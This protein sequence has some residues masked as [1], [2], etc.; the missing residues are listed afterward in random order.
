MKKKRFQLIFNWYAKY[1]TKNKNENKTERFFSFHDCL[2][3]LRRVH[4]DFVCM[5]N[6]WHYSILINC[7]LILCE[8]SIKILGNFSI[9]DYPNNDYFE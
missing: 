8:F 2:S 7:V 6:A 4:G 5:L 1:L 9:T 3:W